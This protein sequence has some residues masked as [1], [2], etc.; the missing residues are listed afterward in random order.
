VVALPCNQFA[1]QEPGSKQE[2]L[3][4]IQYVRPAGGFKPLFPMT[5]K[6]EVNGAQMHDLYT[7]LRASCPESPQPGFQAKTILP[8]EPLHASDIRWNFEKFLIGKD[9]KPVKRFHSSVTPEQLQ[10]EIEKLLATRG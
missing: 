8:Y 10:V 1:F 5:N 3:N 4:G 2:I 9:G 6:I 7:Y